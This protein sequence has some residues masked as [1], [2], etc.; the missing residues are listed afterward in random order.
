MFL[1]P[2]SPRRASLECRHSLY[3]RASQAD[4]IFATAGAAGLPAPIASMLP[5]GQSTFYYPI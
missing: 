3:R 2:I 1:A 5:S 4:A